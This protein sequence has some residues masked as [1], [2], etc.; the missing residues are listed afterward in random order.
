MRKSAKNQYATT[1]APTYSM[2]IAPGFHFCRDNDR[3]VHALNKIKSTNSIFLNDK[4]E[5]VQGFRKFLSE[6]LEV[7]SLA[8][9]PARTN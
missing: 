7:D 9:H 2:H 4:E 8:S 5:F 6:D 3:K 1:P